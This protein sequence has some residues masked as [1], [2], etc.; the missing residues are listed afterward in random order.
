MVEIGGVTARSAAEASTCLG[1]YATTQQ[2]KIRKTASALHENMTK[3]RISAGA[4]VS[5]GFAAHGKTSRF[6]DCWAWG[7]PLGVLSE[8]MIDNEGH[9]KHAGKRRK[10]YT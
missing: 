3:T 9:R 10:Y 7:A 5:L 6:D 4:T 2:D 8:C 1:T